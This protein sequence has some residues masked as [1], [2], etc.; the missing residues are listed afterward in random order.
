MET[1]FPSWFRP[2]LKT[3]AAANAPKSMERLKKF[4][5]ATKPKPLRLS[6]LKHLT[7][8]SGATGGGCFAASFAASFALALTRGGGCTGGSGRRRSWE[9][10]S[11]SFS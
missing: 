10:L 6:A 4:S 11:F 1:T 8:A 2:A 5:D 9:S 3:E 7:K